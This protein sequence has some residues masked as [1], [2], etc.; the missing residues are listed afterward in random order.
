ME[1]IV[2]AVV[3]AF[4]LE[5]AI[6]FAILSGFS[7]IASVLDAVWKDDDQPAIVSQIIKILAVNVGRA[8]NDP[9]RNV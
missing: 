7:F 5:H 6:G 4:G 3:D 1:A 9:D 2:L 8:T